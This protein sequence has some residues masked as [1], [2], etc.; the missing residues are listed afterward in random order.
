MQG[1]SI[2]E[3]GGM[4]KVPFAEIVPGEDGWYTVTLHF[5]EGYAPHHFTGYVPI[6]EIE[7]LGGKWPAMERG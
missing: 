5:P 1:K 6:A 4:V 7:G 3:L 2:K